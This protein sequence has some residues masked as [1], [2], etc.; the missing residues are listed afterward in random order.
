[1]KYCIAFFLVFTF[2]QT[3]E[4]EAQVVGVQ[5]GDTIEIMLDGKKTPVR[6]FG[7]DSPE[8]GQGFSGKAKQYITV[9]CL[10]KKVKII[11]N[12]PDKYGRMVGEVILPDGRS[13]GKELVAAGYTWVYKRFTEDPEMIKLEDQ[14]RKQKKGL[15]IEDNP[16]APWDFRKTKEIKPIN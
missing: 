3:K 5:D 4:F 1:M 11:K 12:K 13:I 10:N 9:L 14:A 6:I 15:W 8:D 2:F 7:I 16:T